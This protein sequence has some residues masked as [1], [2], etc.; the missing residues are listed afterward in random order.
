MDVA[1]MTNVRCQTW[2]FVSKVTER[3]AASLLNEYLVAND[4]LP[5]YISQPIG[6]GRSI[7]RK[8]P[9]GHSYSSRHRRQ[10]TLLGFLD[11]SAAFDCVDRDIIYFTTTSYRSW[12]LRRQS[13]QVDSVIPDQQD[14]R[15]YIQRSAIQEAAA[16][17]WSSA[18]LRSGAAAVPFV[19]CWAWTV[20]FPSWSA[21]LPICQRQPGLH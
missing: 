5:R 14:A 13:A 9:C 19:H 3:A 6:P 12:Y 18:R 4:L 10:L 16:S 1:D 20:D 11:L 8:L 15:S 2:H 17:V 7:Q 21:H